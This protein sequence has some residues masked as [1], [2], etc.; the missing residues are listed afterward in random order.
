V[1]RVR[2][3]VRNVSIVNS[4]DLLSNDVAGVEKSRLA[5]GIL[6]AVFTHP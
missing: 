6:V 2:S 5:Q 3:V 1:D 4:K